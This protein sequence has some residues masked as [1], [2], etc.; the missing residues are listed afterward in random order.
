VTGAASSIGRGIAQ[1]IAREG[2]R[3]VLADLDADRG[4]GVAAGLR[5]ACAARSS[6]AAR[7]GATCASGG[8]AGGW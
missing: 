4:E 6:W 8:S 3:V 5:D 1:A 2:A 7:R